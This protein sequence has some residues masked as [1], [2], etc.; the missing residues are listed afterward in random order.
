MLVV[1]GMC[2]LLLFDLSIG[3]I[4]GTNFYLVFR[5]IQYTYEAKRSGYEHASDADDCH[6]LALLVHPISHRHKS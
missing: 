2:F 4:E 5:C 6:F 1:G 3:T